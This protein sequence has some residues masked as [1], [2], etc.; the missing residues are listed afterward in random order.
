MTTKSEKKQ[1]KAESNLSDG[2][3]GGQVQAS[4]QKRLRAL[5][6]KLRAIET[7]ETAEKQGKEINADQVTLICKQ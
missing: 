5:K 6:K 4:L 3:K 1:A 7:I 2:E